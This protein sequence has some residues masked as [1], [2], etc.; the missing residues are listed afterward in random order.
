MEFSDL[1]QNI[2][3]AL[4]MTRRCSMQCFYCHVSKL[5]HKDTEMNYNEWVNIL[6]PLIGYLKDHDVH[7][8]FV[9]GEPFLFK[10]TV[11]L[12]KHVLN[13][14]IYTSLVSNGLDTPSEIFSDPAFK[15]KDLFCF[16]ISLDGGAKGHEESRL[17]FNKVSKSLEKLV[18][19]SIDIVIRTTVHKRNLTLLDELFQFANDLGKTYKQKIPID[20]QPVAGSPLLVNDDFEIYRLNLDEYLNLALNIHLKMVTDYRFIESQ[21]RFFDEMI[22]NFFNESKRLISVEG[23]FFGCGGG[24][25]FEIHSDGQVARCEMDKPVADLKRDHQKEDM[26][27]L[28]TKLEELNTPNKRCILCSYRWSCGMCRLAPVMHGYT[29][30]FGYNDCTELMLNVKKWHMEHKTGDLFLEEEGCYCEK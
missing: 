3:I 13:S 8:H 22:F 25:S 29:T 28:F 24:F 19:N 10:G 30:G 11:P 23:A 1:Y 27:M 12:L 26:K 21:W 9:G 5:P 6:N 7:M 14:K 4:E 16:N 17:D 20:V 2:C 18:E 15:N